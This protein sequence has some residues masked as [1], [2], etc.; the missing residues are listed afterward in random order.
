[1]VQVC[2]V[3]GKVTQQTSCTIYTPTCIYVQ[4]AL[5]G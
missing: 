1:M 2:Q 5:R 3:A 4:S